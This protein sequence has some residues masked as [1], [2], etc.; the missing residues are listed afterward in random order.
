MARTAWPLCL[1]FA[2][3]IDFKNVKLKQKSEL[4][5]RH[6]PSRPGITTSIRVRGNEPRRS[7]FSTAVV[8]HVISFELK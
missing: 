4:V 3:R 5:A 6:F 1:A 2:D 7:S 8:H